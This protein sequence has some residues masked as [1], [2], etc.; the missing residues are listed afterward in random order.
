MDLSKSET[1]GGKVNFKKVGRIAD[2][3]YS[4][5]YPVER[6]ARDVRV[7]TIYD[8]TSETQRMIIAREL[9]R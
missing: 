7:T 3:G 6:L 2:Y 8:G 9:L 4:Q 1:C 5:E